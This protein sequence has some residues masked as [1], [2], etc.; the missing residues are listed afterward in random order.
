MEQKTS[1]DKIQIRKCR[2]A[3]VAAVGAFYDRIVHWLDNHINYPKWIYRVYPSEPSAREMTAA[4][5]QYI[6]M[7]DREI[8]A[9]FVL[10]TDPQGSYQKGEWAR[11]LPDGSYMV[12]HALAI[13][14][15][16]QG[17]GLGAKVVRFCVEKAKAD[18]FKA[19]RVD[20]VPGNL[21]ARKLYEKCGFQYAGDVDLERG[22]AHIPVFSLYELNW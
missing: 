1:N 17:Q 7:D 6:C 16:L 3:D 2:E 22:L 10:N 18:G 4:G 19:L 20:I 11:D 12:L 21:P 14:P 13:A 15:E 8:I 9:A 5:E